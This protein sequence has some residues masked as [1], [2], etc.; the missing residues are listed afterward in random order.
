MSK[1]EDMSKIKIQESKPKKRMPRVIMRKSMKMIEQELIDNG[2]FTDNIKVKE[3]N[4]DTYLEYDDEDHVLIFHLE[5]SKFFNIPTHFRIPKEK[6]KTFSLEITTGA[7]TIQTVCEL[8][9]NHLVNKDRDFTYYLLDEPNVQF[10]SAA[11][12]KPI[13]FYNKWSIIDKNK[14]DMQHYHDLKTTFDV[15]M[16]DRGYPKSYE[17]DGKWYSRMDS[18]KQVVTFTITETENTFNIDDYGYKEDLEKNKKAGPY[19]KFVKLK[20]ARQVETEDTDEKLRRYGLE[21]SLYQ[22]NPEG[23]IQTLL[24]MGIAGEKEYQNVKKMLAGTKILSIALE[25]E[26]QSEP[27]K[28]KE[29]KKQKI[30][31]TTTSGIPMATGLP[32]AGMSGVP[33]TGIPAT[34]PMPARIPMGIPMGQSIIPQMPQVIPMNPIQQPIVQVIPQQRVTEQPI[35]PGQTVSVTTTEPQTVRMEEEPSTT[36][37][38]QS[39]DL[40]SFL[41]GLQK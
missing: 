31:T 41:Q 11:S 9:G 4:D 15:F 38:A 32:M 1:P 16:Y 2:V 23:P 26:P 24:C 21:V 22:E 20:K 37:S 33:I 34:M 10:D 14:K 6:M 28:D 13:E 39:G 7:G 40:L 5:A 3:A 18:R 8:T 19:E 27:M 25:I 17:K 12:F 30:N 29:I 35:F 36:N